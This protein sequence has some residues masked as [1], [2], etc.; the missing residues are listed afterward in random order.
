MNRLNEINTVFDAVTRALP[1]AGVPFLL[2]GGHAV[3]HYGYTR[4]TMDVDFMIT[5]DDVASVREVM[6]SEGFTNI[7]AGDTVI[8]FS[9]PG[10]AL[11]VDFLPVD[12]ETLE[13]LLSGSVDVQYGGVALKVPSLNDLLAMKLFALKTGNPLRK[14]RDFADIV[15]LV[16]LNNLDEETP[17]KILCENFATE[18]IYQKIRTRIQELRNA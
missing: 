5:T 13:Q 17:L 9:M 8:F 16:F 15:Q 7:S 4:A 11:R 10:S 2:I 6:K 14:D 3:N 1:K 18:A 12:H